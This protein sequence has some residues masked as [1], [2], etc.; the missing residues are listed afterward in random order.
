MHAANTAIGLEPE[1]ASW[2]SLRASVQLA[3]SDW[4]AAL[5]DADAGLALDAE[6]VELANLRAIALLQL[7]RRNEAATTAEGVLRRSP[8][9]SLSHANQGW[10]CLHENNPRKAQE[11]F[12]EA[13]RLE[14]GLEFARRGMLEAL[15]ARNPVY[16]VMLAYF[17]WMGR[18][19]KRIQWA[20]IIFTIF[21]VRIVRQTA[22]ANPELGLF[23]WP[24]VVGFYIFIY[25]SWTAQPVFNL[26][27][28]FDRFGRYVLSREERVA[29]NWYGASLLLIP[30]TAV[31]WWLDRGIAPLFALISGVMFSV[32]V[33]A[34]FSRTGRNRLIVGAATAVLALVA[35]AATVI[36]VKSGNPSLFVVFFFGFLGFQILANVF[37][38]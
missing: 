5:A 34:S 24:L 10:R 14:P 35:I 32:C 2:Y 4:K 37:S 31:W 9:N 17:L 29:S 7:G 23:L 25:L 28:R 8:E 19:S 12:R 36:T 33:A 22:A 18:Q 20:F 6:N 21:V 13:L 30:A 26:M 16:R 38:E 27:L 1:N 15:K 3:K 11:H